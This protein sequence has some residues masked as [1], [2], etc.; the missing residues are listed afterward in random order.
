MSKASQLIR[1]RTTPMGRVA[2][3]AATLVALV[4][5][6]AAPQKWR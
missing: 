5:T 1:L 3:T 2:V 6:V 4:V